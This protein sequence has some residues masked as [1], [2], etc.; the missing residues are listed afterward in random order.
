[1]EFDSRDS[2]YSTFSKAI[3]YLRKYL[4]D[5]GIKEAEFPS[6]KLEK[7]SL[8][9]DEIGERVILIKENKIYSVSGDSENMEKVV[10]WLIN[11]KI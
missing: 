5:T 1:L 11:Q 6:L 10:L 3:E 8:Y 7:G 4:R 2:A 9:T